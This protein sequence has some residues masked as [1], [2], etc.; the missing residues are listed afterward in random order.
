MISTRKLRRRLRL[1]GLRTKWFLTGQNIRLGSNTRIDSGAVIESGRGES[2]HIG[3]NCHIHGG[4]RLLTY[5]GN[6]EIGDHTSVNPYSILY[7]H[8]GLQIKD[9]VMIAAHCVV[10]PANHNIDDVSVPMR[11]QGLSCKGIVIESDVWL[12]SGARVLDGVTIAEGCVI[13]AGAVVAKSTEAR[14]IYLGVP[15]NRVRDR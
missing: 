4:A 3:A 9:N 10:I 12:G 13:G 11:K 6:I 7:G 5:G 2:I 14:G 1:L 8:G 15:A